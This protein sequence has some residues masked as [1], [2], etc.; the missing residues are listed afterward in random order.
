M[1]GALLL[2]RPLRAVAGDFGLSRSALHRHLR[3]HV[4]GTVEAAVARATATY[5]RDLRS[6]VRRVQN[7]VLAIL[8]GARQSGD[9]ALALQAAAEARAIS[10]SMRKLLRMAGPKPEEKR[11]AEPPEVEIHYQEAGEHVQ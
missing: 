6:Y 4:R 1:D 2:G 5:T 3:K 11:A 8:T 10:E 9:A 7:E